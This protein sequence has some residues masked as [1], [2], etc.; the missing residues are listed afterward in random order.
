MLGR[1]GYAQ[2]RECQTKIKNGIAAA[3][4]NMGPRMNA[5]KKRAE[6]ASCD[7]S[8]GTAAMG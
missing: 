2:D 3:I 1:S 8:M 6:K 7:I 4:Q 5:G